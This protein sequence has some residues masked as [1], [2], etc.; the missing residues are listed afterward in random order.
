MTDILMLCDTGGECVLLG[1]AL[2]AAPLVVLVA[3]IALVTA[4]QNG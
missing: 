1:F 4:V 3:V 2:A